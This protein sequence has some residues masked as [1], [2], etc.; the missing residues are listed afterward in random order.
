MPEISQ[1]TA[2]TGA[3]NTASRRLLERCGFRLTQALP[4]TDE[5]CYTL[6]VS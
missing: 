5:V 6:G 4:D 2:V 3:G 1:I